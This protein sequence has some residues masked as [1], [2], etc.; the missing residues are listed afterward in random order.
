MINDAIHDMDDYDN[1]NKTGRKGK[2]KKKS[3]TK[4]PR[5][6]GKGKSKRAIRC[7]KC[8]RMCSNA[9]STNYYGPNNMNGMSARH[10]DH[11]GENDG[12]YGDYYD[13]K[14]KDMSKKY[15]K[16]YDEMK[17]KMPKK[18]CVGRGC[19]RCRS[20]CLKYGRN[21]FD[22]IPSNSYPKRGEHDDDD[23][24]NYQYPMNI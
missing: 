16:Y 22:K 8:D 18:G 1:D 20:M 15:G 3:P 14:T 19:R 6:C 23:Y 11:D 9:F 5:R 24:R 17:K 10:Y 4:N 21:M 13:G 12:Y 7:R 2:G